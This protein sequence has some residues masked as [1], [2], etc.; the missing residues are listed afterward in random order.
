[1]FIF[2]AMLSKMTLHQP[3]LGMVWIY[4]EN[5]IEEDLC[6]VPSL[7]RHRTSGMRSIDANMRVITVVMRS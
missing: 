3:G 4:A 1:M 5:S 2:S 6:N 7:F